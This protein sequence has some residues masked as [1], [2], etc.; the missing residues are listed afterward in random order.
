MTVSKSLL[1]FALLAAP[2]A[3]LADPAAPASTNDEA[4]KADGDRMICRTQS[5]TGS[6]L[7]RKRVCMTANE[8][9]EH[10]FRQGQAHE[11]K[12]AELPKAGS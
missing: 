12:T 6:R 7:S 9:R 11:R 4:K 1:A 2:V 3:V 10:S 5:E 8:W